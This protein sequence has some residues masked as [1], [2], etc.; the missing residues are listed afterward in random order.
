M[1][2]LMPVTASN[3]YSLIFQFFKGQTWLIFH[4]FLLFGYKVSI[5][6]IYYDFI[7]KQSI[8]FCMQ[9]KNEKFKIL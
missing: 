8:A 3:A 2:D 6:N 9:F 4:Y 5:Q 1:I 7:N